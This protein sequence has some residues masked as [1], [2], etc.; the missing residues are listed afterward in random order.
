VWIDGMDLL[1]RKP[2]FFPK[3]KKEEEN[4]IH[5]FNSYNKRIGEDLI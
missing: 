1:R 3:K 5:P 2:N 4:L